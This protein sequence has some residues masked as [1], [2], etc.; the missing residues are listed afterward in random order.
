MPQPEIY[1]NPETEEFRFGLWAISALT[2]ASMADSKN[3]LA[4]FEKELR[5]KFAKPTKNIK[6][7][8]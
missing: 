1:I 6:T 3:V 8:R 7:K 2:K 5:R 4:E